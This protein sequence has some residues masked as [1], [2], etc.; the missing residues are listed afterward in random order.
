M[1]IL[2]AGRAASHVYHK[3]VASATVHR[4]ATILRRMISYSI[5]CVE[6]GPGLETTKNPA[7]KKNTSIRQT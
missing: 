3:R 1:G 6:P 5:R 7:I 4:S 2:N